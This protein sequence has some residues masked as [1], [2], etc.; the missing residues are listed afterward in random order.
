MSERIVLNPHESLVNAVADRIPTDRRNFSSIAVVFPGKRPGHFLRRELARR[1]K[2]SF[3]PPRLF[4]IDEFVQFVFDH[5]NPTPVK[6]LDAMDAMAIL[7][8]IHTELR[9]RLGGDVFRS[10]DLFLPIGFKLFGELEELR[11]SGLR[12]DRILEALQGIPY[13]YRHTIGQYYDEFYR[14]LEA[15]KYSTRAMRYAAAAERMEE[16]DLG[17]FEQ[18]IVAGLFKLTTAEQRIVDDLMRREAVTL[19]FQT[20]KEETSDSPPEVLLTCAPDIHGQVFALAESLRSE[21][22]GTQP[23]DER[24]VI[25]LPAADAL[26]PVAEHIL[27]GLPENS[28]NVA[29]GYPLSRTPIVGF[30]SALLDLLQ[31]RQ[32]GRYAASAYVAF[33]LHPYAKNIRF[34]NRTDV[35]RMLVHGLEVLLADDRSKL[36]VSLED[37]EASEELFTRLAFAVEDEANPITPDELSAHLRQMHDRT[38][39]MLEGIT[40]VGSLAE[41]VINILSY[42]YD[43]STA[44]LHPMFRPYAETMLE[45][46][47]R[48]RTSLLASAS[49]ERM[50]GYISFVRHVIDRAEVPFPGTPLRGLQVL[51]MLETRGLQFDRVC[52]LQ[53]TDDVL[54]GGIGSDMLLPQQV[55]ERLG[56]ETIHDRDELA[57]HHFRLL[58]AGAKNVEL[59]FSES[60]RS[61]RSRFVEKLI[62]DRQQKE[63]NTDASS[64]VRSVRYGLQLT[65]EAPQPIAK[66]LEVTAALNRMSFSPTALNA[67]IQCPLRFYYQNVLKLRV[68]DDAADTVDAK[69]VGTFVH[70]ILRAYYEPFV[71]K[72][73]SGEQI[74]KTSIAALIV[75]KFRERYG[76]HPAGALPLIL[77]QVTRRLEE[78]LRAYQQPM[79]ESTR[80]RILSLE[81]PLKATLFGSVF[82][83][84][85]DRIEERGDDICIIDYKTGAPTVNSGIRYSALDPNDRS[86]YGRAIGSLQ[87]PCYVMMY[88]EGEN[89][90]AERIIASY[91]FLGSK[92]MDRNAEELCGDD[93][94]QRMERYQMI[95]TVIE[96]VLE[97]IKNPAVPFLPTNDLSANCPNCPFTGICGTKWV[98]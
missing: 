27:S 21:L 55:R 13:D 92:Q 33:M 52:M 28:Y 89:V 71:G 85:A 59:Y 67:Y 18:I 9:E 11:L 57:E 64:Y 98:L 93:V 58:I 43:N 61:V 88:A 1:L 15:R 34:R 37:L 60:G 46:F 49:F 65:N 47:A 56:L 63:H 86:T 26:F 53:V 17:E 51:G 23:L 25:V 45:S 35:T 6:D 29:F 96:C 68:K 40:S 22:D 54:P 24:T 75:Q 38:I 70:D 42:I 77:K 81:S 79:C 69:E 90:P 19:I 14:R 95:R 30:L 16:A 72:Q 80:I 8:E 48:V 12:E 32:A 76:E 78:Y 94:T 20:D 31:S 87:L 4:S 83:G 74:K 7:Y 73:L 50:E 2:G 41:A 97:E 82:S 84:R 44:P 10:L 39:R 3:I 5:L 36:L 62:W 66:T 91:Q